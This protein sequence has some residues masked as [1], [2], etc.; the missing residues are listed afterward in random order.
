MKF[1]NGFWSTL[2]RNI[3]ESWGDVVTSGVEMTKTVQEFGKTLKEQAP[4]IESL[5][6]YAEKIEP[7]LKAFD[8]PVTQLAVSGLPF[9]S[10]G[11]SALKLYSQLTK[12][13][14]T[15]ADAVVVA[16]QLAYLESLPRVLMSLSKTDQA[17]LQKVVSTQ[18]I[19][20]QL[21]RLKK[22][23]LGQEDAEQA[24]SCFRKS[25]LAKMFNE[26]LV[27]QLE[28]AGF[29]VQVAE[30]LAEG[31]SWQTPRYLC[32]VLA[33]A[34]DQIQPL[35]QIHLN[36]QKTLEKYQG[37]EAYLEEKIKRLPDQ[38]ILSEEDDQSGLRITYR[39]LYV[40]LKV[41]RLDA[42]GKAMEA[43]A[44]D[45]HQWLSS[46]LADRK[47]QRRVL[48]IQGDAGRGKSVFCRMFADRVRT[49]RYLGF[50]P[51][52]IRLRDVQVLENNITQTLTTE[53]ENLHFVQSDDG[54]LADENTRFLLLLD[55]FDELLLEG[56]KEGLK[57]FLQQVAD[58]Q[59]DSHHQFVVTGRPLALQGIERL[60]SQTGNLERVRLEPM[61]DGIR[62]Q[63]LAKWATK[64]GEPETQAFTQFLQACPDE[65]ND[66]SAREPLLLYLLA[67]LHREE[68]VNAAMLA[69]AEGIEARVKIYD[70]SVNWVLEKQ[71]QQE[72]FRQTGL[73]TAELRRFAMEAALCVVQS[74]NETAKLTM[75]EKRCQ[76]SDNPGAY[77]LKRTREA[78]A[79][80]ESKAL[81]NLLT[82]F[83][84]N[85]AAGDQGGGIEFAHE[86]FGEF[87]FAERLKI[88]LEEWTEWDAR[89]NRFV[90][91][92]DQMNKQIYDLLGYGG[93]TQEVV[94]YLMGLLTN[95]K[96]A[97]EFKPV[98]L[99]QRLHEF[100]LGWS[101]GE[102]IDQPPNKNFPQ[103]KMLQMQEQEIS[104]GLR[105]VDVHTGLNV[106]I[107]LLEL[108]RYAKE[109]NHNELKNDI[110]FY[111]CGEPETES[112]DAQR[113]LRI[114]HYS[115][116]FTYGTFSAIAIAD[117]SGANLSG[118][119]LSAANLSGANLIGA[120][121]SAA[122]LIGANLSNTDLSAAN[123][124]SA[125]LWSANLS[126]AN[127][128]GSNLSGA[129][130]S[131][132]D[133]S[134]AWLGEKNLEERDQWI[135]EVEQEYKNSEYDSYEK[136]LEAQQ[137][138]GSTIVFIGRLYESINWDETTNWDRVQGLETAKNVPEE[139]KRQLGLK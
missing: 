56:R 48:F 133:F 11:V 65:I 30:L 132:A 82:T 85:P 116:C 78:T 88:S 1:L 77:L 137:E 12:Q 33:A 128:S 126:S 25:K 117:L 110:A 108:N 44:I 49:Q 129:Y 89:R 72:N 92:T 105:Q 46:K 18:I 90:T 50:V 57:E 131:Y 75:L 100:Y 66:N 102:F 7:F 34:K 26:V 62:Q 97:P 121:L 135:R 111:P 130:L 39:D 134:D 63:W 52:L 29:Q 24:I 71:R 114:I 115:D 6:P 35:T 107:L 127:L 125:N 3:G 58:F 109:S 20:Q 68:Q 69:G 98:E 91:D 36:V 138:M 9:L 54:W 80:T 43:A 4:E 59:K 17:K 16:F 136:H 112:F 47:S 5:K 101:K 123:L 99:F 79:Q 40:P 93:L 76:R 15:F 104:S 120:N 94:G 87:L 8:S 113:L 13:E 70:A 118:A 37:I 103:D 84:I 61:E 41:Q 19:R 31:V 2:N 21:E 124:G 55:G 74:G 51:L 83:Y 60:I 22:D 139:L 53:L 32:R 38:T 73:K 106:M 42:D 122:N 81:N 64:A 23:E 96:Y 119:N 27:N 10:I 45:I 95:A 28:Q 86:S 14:P 67:R